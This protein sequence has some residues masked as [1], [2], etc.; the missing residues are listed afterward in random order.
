[1]YSNIM[2]IN[3][4]DELF[5]SILNKLNNYLEN[6][7]A[8]DKLSLDTNFVKYQ[9]D[10]LNYIK[11]FIETIPKKDITNIIKKDEYYE[12]I[13][14]IIK[15][16][17]AFYIYLGIGYYYEG[18]RDLFITNIIETSRY[19]KDSKI[20]IQNF[21]NSENNFKIIS[22]YNDIKNFISLIQ[23][24]TIDKIKIILSNNPQRYETTISLFNELGEDY[25]L[26]YFLIKDN[27]H[28]M[29]KAIIFKQIYLKEEKNE[30]VNILNQQDKTDVEYK[31]I[32]IV[33]SNQKKLVDFNVIQKFLTISELKSGLAEEIYNY[34]E[35]NRDNRELVIKEN[36]DY[37]NYLFSNNILI[38]ITE[39][40]LRYHKDTEKYDPESLVENSNIKEREATKIKY[41]IS[42]MNNV[43]NYHSLL[44]DNNP[45]LKLET[46]KLFFKPLQPK[47]AV[48]FN[49]N[50]EI[51]IIQK[52]EISEN[53]TDYDLLIDLLNIRKYSYVNFKKMLKDGI[54]IRPEKTI[55][56]IRQ[57]SLLQKD[58]VAIETRIGHDNIDMNV[59][60]IAFNPSKKSLDCF[61]KNNFI[62]VKNKNESNGFKQF[63][64]ILNET[65]DTKDNKLYYWLFDSKTDKSTSKTYVNYTNNIQNNIKLMILEIYNIYINL[66]TNKLKKYFKSVESITIWDIYN[67]FKAYE[68][69]YFDFKLN[70]SI[71]NE[72]IEYALINKVL[73]LE[74][75]PDEI[76]SIIPGK[77]ESIIEL[78]ILKI[79]KEK[80]NIIKIGDTDI[81][82][83]I[84]DSKKYNPI[85][86][87]YIKWRNI[88]YIKNID[89]YNQAIFD[90]VK[91]YVSLNDKGEYFC[92]GCQEAVK[93]EKFE[94]TYDQQL[95][96][97]LITS[98]SVGERLE[99]IPKYSK[100]MRTIRNLE[101]NIE[102]F[103]YSMDIISLL[104]NSP[105]ARIRRKSIIK[106]VIDI[107]L[108]HTE[109]LR[110][111]PKN[112]IEQYNQ[113]YGIG[114][115]L[116]NLFFFELK[117]EIFLTSSTDT[118][119]YKIIKY[120]NIMAYLIVVILTE[121]NS[122]QLINLKDDK[123]INYFFYQKIGSSIFS[124]LFLRVNQKQK[125]PLINIPLL[126]YIIYYL[127]GIMVSN[128]L[129]LYNDKNIDVKDKP[130]FLI[131]TQKTII[132]TV[133]DLLNTLF[134][135]NTINDKN[136]IY[137][138]INTRISIKIKN[139]YY[140][141]QL[142]KR[143]ESK[144][145][146]NIKFDE[147]TKKITFL[148]KKINFVELNINYTDIENHIQ[149]CSLKTY[150]LNKLKNKTDNNLIDGFT[151]CSDG[152]F[153][154]W[155]FM[156]KNNDLICEICNKSYNEELK[157][158]TTTSSENHTSDYLDKLKYINL[159][160]LS[161]KYCISGENHDIDNYGICSKC[162]VDINKFE[163]T[164][165]ELKLLDKNIDLK[166]NE[167]ILNQINLINEIKNKNT[168]INENIKE[169]ISNFNKEYDKIKDL[170]LENYINSFV[171]KLIKILGNK[172]KVNDK[173]IYLKE[174]V[175]IIDHDY[176][177]NPMKNTINILSSDNKIQYA[178]K[179]ASFDKDVI[180]YKDKSNNVYVYYDS[181]TMQY[182]G[183]SEDNKTIKKNKN[184]P[185]LQI[186]L[187]IKD[188]II[189]LG[190][191]NQYYNIY[192]I[193]KDFQDNLPTEL[194]KEYIL[195]IIRNRIND[196]KQ[197]IIRTNSII[198]NIR[199]S[200]KILSNYNINEKEIVNE[201]TKKL[202]K[203][204][205]SNGKDDIFKNFK[206]ILSNIHINYKIPDN[207]IIN[208][209]KNYIDINIIN[210]LNNSDIKLIFYLIDNL[211][212]L[213]DYNTQPAIESELAHLIIKII[214]FLFN[215][216]YRPYFNY[217][218][219]KFDYLLLNETVYIDETLRVVGHFQELLTQNEID[220]P[221]K[222]EEEYSLKEASDAFDIDDYVDEEDKKYDDI[223]NT[224]E[225]LDGYE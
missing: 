51:K 114:K 181:I 80:K 90:F 146:K 219:R 222:K 113:K 33:I 201:F 1:M 112:R 31:F 144:S 190:Y 17:C 71:K 20:Q 65:F 79:I 224:I 120:N 191:E 21:F 161:K 63:I 125:V 171:D 87:H 166:T 94:A 223:D 221:D 5:D 27:F 28:N 205:I 107:I 9:N 206:E 48:L 145:L 127:S 185:S 93:M 66:V 81:D 23:L 11:N 86:H 136:F 159:H 67:I 169:I 215:M 148:T 124:N 138:I 84:I 210:T 61:N 96:T 97:F 163:A 155:I 78:P 132:N 100:Y 95:D 199:N 103:A 186:E 164:D 37:I 214:K 38:P 34:L 101:K 225:A 24:K 50:E 73:E 220:D 110:G 194:N 198:N 75:V 83:K 47:L 42:K 92:K 208:L 152:K 15:R 182:L 118:D 85:C 52:L 6:H 36:D 153:H 188:S 43:K 162:K 130:L 183:Y 13:L 77:N 91:Q 14:N 167:L 58:N 29:L 180:Y 204:N 49:D 197:I 53:A 121:L 35:E 2:Y 126:A 178:Y 89:D 108:V 59:I 69:N 22:F 55:Q 105:D 172:I 70:P 109:W 123:R 158:L 45:K 44:L 88:R 173:I 119:Q 56:G 32:E 216:Y 207:F 170:K 117:D 177:G 7:K 150:K 160:K 142:L 168:K 179:H 211:N 104:G 135:A 115:D 156:K 140:D 76:D 39:D 217:N 60:G 40:F 141:E 111:Q 200:G 139:I 62:N 203:F 18:G 10:I 143:I 122:G 82:I 137:E 25:I 195:K 165:K 131:N 184:N 98:I 193:N 4:I 64:N 202:K 149:L 128:R 147:T 187:S 74:I 192:H 134:E 189:Y 133:V 68:K 196:L 41:I 175:Y 218:I 116:T 157:N 151:N 26:E 129:W 106:D 212:K 99:D 176:L 154:K 46:E 8:F 174:T 57:T 19:Q 3:Q 72:L 54:K 213:L 30:I 12:I 102:K 209:N 16:Y